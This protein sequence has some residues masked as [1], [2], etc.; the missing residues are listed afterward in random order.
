MA[1][2]LKTEHIDGRTQC[3]V[4][5]D[6]IEIYIP[7]EYFEGSYAMLQ[8]MLCESLGLFYFKAEGNLH[9]LRMPVKIEFQYIGQPEKA[10]LVLKPG[11]PSIKYRIFTLTR[12]CA[13]IWNL[14]REKSSDDLL[15][16]VT[17][18][19]E[20][21]KWPAFVSY[22]DMV[23]LM[24]DVYRACDESA[25]VLDV[26]S[27]IVEMLISQ[28]ARYKPDAAV[29]MRMKYTGKNKY[30]YRPVRLTRV[31]SA[32]STMNALMGEDMSKQMVASVLR[33]RE[34]KDEP[35]SEIEEVIKY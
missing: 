12:G 5:T 18:F 25:D 21:G 15:F 17:N 30:D 11:M 4:N 28:V 22:D 1:S 14:H 29:P 9:L 13:F 8:S 10:T 34:G 35:P 33:T 6:K 27:V 26:P 23:G 16:I 31:T 32:M 19:L 24:F 7:E 20:N 3:T 2:Y